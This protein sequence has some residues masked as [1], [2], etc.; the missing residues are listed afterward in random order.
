MPIPSPNKGENKH[1]F[2]QKCMSDDVMNKEFND[3][4]QRYAVCLQKWE[5]RKKKA[6]AIVKLEDNEFIY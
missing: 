1:D 6:S 3:Q 5:D 2:I 4:K